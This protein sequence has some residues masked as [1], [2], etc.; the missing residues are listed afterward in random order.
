MDDAHIRISDLIEYYKVVA[1][2]NEESSQNEIDEI[3]SVA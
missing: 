3:I 1:N 2:I